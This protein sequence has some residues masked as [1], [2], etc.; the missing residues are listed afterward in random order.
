LSS[1]ILMIVLAATGPRYTSHSAIRS[2]G[3]RN[4]LCHSTPQPSESATSSIE[5]PRNDGGRE[6][7]HRHRPPYSAG[8]VYGLQCNCRAKGLERVYCPRQE[9][10]AG[11]H[12]QLRNG[13]APNGCRGNK[14]KCGNG[15]AARGEGDMIQS[16]VIR[17]LDQGNSS[18]P[19]ISVGAIGDSRHTRP[20]ISG[21]PNSIDYRPDELKARHCLCPSRIEN[22]KFCVG[23]EDQ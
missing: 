11:G 21:F 17:Q 8:H 22:D 5:V 14:M 12:H 16:D 1:A 19:H 15:R 2:T 7:Q 13:A 6:R 4:P 10:Q 3:N 9:R 20:R 18:G 23:R